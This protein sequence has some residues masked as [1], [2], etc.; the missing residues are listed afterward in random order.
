MRKF[1]LGAFVCA[2]VIVGIGPAKADVAYSQNF[3]TG[4]ASFTA[5]DPYWLTQSDANDWIV[6][7][8]TQVTAFP[9]GD[10]IPQDVSGS[11]Y[12]LFEGT[13]A[14]PTNGGTIPAGQD[15]FFISPTFSVNPGTTYTVSFYVTDANGI[16]NPVLQPEIDGSLL[17]SPVSPAGD[18]DISGWQ[19]VSFTWNSGSNTSASLILHD[20]VTT[21]D[22][23]DFGV[24]DILV[25]SPVPEPGAWLLFGSLVLVVLPTLRRLAR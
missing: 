23:N 12:F 14:Y 25:S 21:P 20:Y 1:Y 13:A 24:D 17:G 4:S 7:N 22:G 2:L 18:Y 10:A 16:N 8:T 11:G 5:N 6:Q 3:D 15:Q 19:Q 9:F